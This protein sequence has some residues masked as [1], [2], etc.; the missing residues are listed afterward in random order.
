[1]RLTHASKMN[2]RAVYST[3]A[4]ATISGSIHIAHHHG[5]V[6]VRRATLLRQE[7]DSPA[8]P[9]DPA[10]FRPFRASHTRASSLGRGDGASHGPVGVPAGREP[11]CGF[12]KPWER[13]CRLVGGGWNQAGGNPGWPH[14]STGWTLET[15]R[16]RFAKES[17]S[18]GLDTRGVAAWTRVISPQWFRISPN[19]DGS[20]A[21]YSGGH[22]RRR[23]VWRPRVG[24][25]WRRPM[26]REASSLHGF[27]R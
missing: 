16:S 12:G 26:W 13:A 14:L 11:T 3:S 25:R 15:P 21:S 27:S 17:N 8:A 18:F 23:A 1:M 4:V 9:C 5:P 7:S 19:C 2:S 6:V 24:G 22:A 20:P 10:E